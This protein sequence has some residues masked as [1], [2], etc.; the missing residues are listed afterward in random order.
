M[1][2][3]HV[4]LFR[5]TD[6]ATEQQLAAVVDGFDHLPEQV[7][8]IGVYQHGPDVGINADSFVYGLVADFPDEATYLVYR[9]HPAHRAFITERIR[10]ILAERAAI[11][12]LV[13]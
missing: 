4:V 9:D 5:W 2:F 6:D 1:T 10:P 3:R 8:E 12:Y 13:D 11:Q 7:P